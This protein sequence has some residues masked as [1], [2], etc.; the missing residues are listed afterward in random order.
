[1]HRRGP[2]SLISRPTVAETYRFRDSID[3]CVKKLLEER[4]E[5]LV[6]EIE[7]ILDAR[8]APLTATPELLVTDIKHVFARI[9]S[10]RCSLKPLRM[11]D[12]EC[13]P[14]FVELDEVRYAIGHGGAGFFR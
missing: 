3:E 9:P 6:A 5:A 4:K 13:G 14:A 11:W 2:G 10:T 7:P 1:M 12:R 8:P